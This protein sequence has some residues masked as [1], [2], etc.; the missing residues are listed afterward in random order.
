MFY[1][2][3]DF[4]FIFSIDFAEGTCK[5]QGETPFWCFLAPGISRFAPFKIQKNVFCDGIFKFKFFFAISHDMISGFLKQKVNIS[6][7]KVCKKFHNADRWVFPE[8]QIQWFEHY[9]IDFDDILVKFPDFR[10]SLRGRISALRW[11]W[12][13]NEPTRTIYSSRKLIS[14]CFK[15]PKPTLECLKPSTKLTEFGKIR[16]APLQ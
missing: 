8:R 10:S 5:I 7:M 13:T 4:F 16:S 12:M 1:D 9:S 6:K 3:T 14:R 11:G 2:H 15:V